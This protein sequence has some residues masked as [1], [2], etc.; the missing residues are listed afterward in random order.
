MIITLQYCDV[1]LPYIDMNQP[2]VYMCLPVLNPPSIPLLIPSLWDVPVYWL[3]M[4][5]F[6]RQTW[7]GYL[8]HMVIYMF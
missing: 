5:C 7:T 3:R 1:F 2:W 4:P 6:M 8:F